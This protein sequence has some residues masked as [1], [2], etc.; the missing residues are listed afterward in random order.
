[1]S[2]LPGILARG[3]QHLAAAARFR[4]DGHGR[5]LCPRYRAAGRAPAAGSAHT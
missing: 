4:V 5:S 2:S 1:M 3:R